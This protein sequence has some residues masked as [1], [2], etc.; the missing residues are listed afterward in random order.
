MDDF[1]A[2]QQQVLEGRSLVQRMETALQA[3][4]SQP[5]LPGNQEPSHE[6]VSGG[7]LLLPW[8][9]KGMCG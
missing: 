8:R 6:L 9:C 3:C 4:L 2:L 5:P 7:E 1:S